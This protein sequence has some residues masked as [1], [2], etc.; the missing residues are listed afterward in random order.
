MNKIFYRK[1][2]N[3]KSRILLIKVDINEDLSIQIKD[4][5]EK[6][7]FLSKSQYLDIID[8]SVFNE[9]LFQ[10]DLFYKILVNYAII[11]NSLGVEQQ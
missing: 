3:W 11:T 10:S 8:I 6:Q 5:L 4:E 7:E 9:D 2:Q 1:N